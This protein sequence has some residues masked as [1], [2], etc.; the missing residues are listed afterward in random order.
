MPLT[1][2]KMVCIQQRVSTFPSSIGSTVADQV[3]N[4]RRFPT[5]LSC[6]LVAE[7]LKKVKSVWINFIDEQL[8]LKRA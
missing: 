4:N 5:H 7:Y 1:V 6:F 3:L 2:G 8:K